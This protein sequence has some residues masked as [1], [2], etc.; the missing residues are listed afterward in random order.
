VHF[1]LFILDDHVDQ[2]VCLLNQILSYADVHALDLLAVDL[3]EPDLDLV[4]D[5]FVDVFDDFV[6]DQ[7]E[8]FDFA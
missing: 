7:Q 6:V 2:E 1:Q 8:A 3:E 5:T 4:R